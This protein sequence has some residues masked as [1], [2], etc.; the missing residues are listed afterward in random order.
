MTRQRSLRLVND[1]EHARRCEIPLSCNALTAPLRREPQPFFE[2]YSRTASSSIFCLAV[3]L[4]ICE[5]DL[6]ML[7]SSQIARFKTGALVFQSR[8]VF[9]WIPCAA[10]LGCRRSGLKLFDSS[11]DLSFAEA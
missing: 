9:A 8:I 6:E 1:R 4:C 10:E 3:M 2:I 5:S 7:E 11:N